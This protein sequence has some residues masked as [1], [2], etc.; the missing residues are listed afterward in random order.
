MILEELT[1]DP[2]RL[3]ERTG[4][5]MKPE[6][7]CKGDRCVPLPAQ[8]VTDGRLDA[9]VLAD[10]LG[11]PL[12]HDAATGVW[13]LGPES[14]SARLASAELPPI[15]LPDLEGRPFDLRSLHGQ[16]VLLLAWATW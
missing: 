14:E 11:M 16:K 13:A 6:G 8:A 5:V 10:R 12:V 9:R 4:W 3:E 7:L 15:V 2:A 1:V